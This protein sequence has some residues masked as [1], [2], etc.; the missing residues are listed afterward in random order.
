MAGARVLVA[1]DRPGAA[2]L[3]TTILRTA[4][5]D[6]A[7]VD[8]EYTAT[9]VL[10]DEVVPVVVASFSGRGVGATTALLRELRSRPEPQLRGAG[11]VAIVDDPADAAFGIGSEADAVLVR[12][13]DAADLVDAVTEVASTGRR[14]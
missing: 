3:I 2:Q 12:P 8:H 10:T 6:A 4:G 5:F 11:V 1:E 13:V 14:R 7:P 9:R